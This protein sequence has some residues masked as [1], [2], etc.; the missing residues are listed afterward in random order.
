MLVIACSL[1]VT[2]GS[3]I[4]QPQALDAEEAG[5][6]GDA[7]ATAAASATAATTE[8][9]AV[10][11][12][13]ASLH[14]W[15]AA[16]GGQLSA[17]ILPVN[18]GEPIA[19]ANPD[20]ALNPASNMKLLTAA[21]ALDLLG[22][23]HRFTTGLYGQIQGDVAGP[24]VLR[25][26]GD[27]SLRTAE[28]W[29]LV[30]A[31]TQR[32]VTRID[33]PL[34]VDQTRFEPDFVPPAFDQ[35]PDEWAAFRAPISAIALEQNAVTLNV[36]AARAGE[37]A[38]VW[39]EPPGFVVVEGQVGTR[40]AGAGQGVTLS[41]AER[42]GRLRARVGGHVAAGTGR[43]RF[44]RRV[45]DP[46][47]FAGY[48]FLELARQ[49]GIQVSGEVSPGDGKERRRIA[50]VESE[51][52]GTL[53]N[54]LGKSSDNFYAEMIFRGLGAEAVG[55][56]ARSA[57]GARVVERWL[58]GAGAL[59]ERTRVL[60]GSGL[61]DANRVSSRDL[62]TALTTAYLD[63]ALGADFV[64]QLSIAGVD[65]TLRSRLRQHRKRRIV[66]AK[67]GTLNSVVALSGYALGPEPRDAVA[68][69]FIVEGLPG[70]HSESRRRI[71]ACVD[72][73]VRSLWQ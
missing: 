3:A 16:S 44:R 46:R 57:D 61:F 38:R 68:F 15:V 2:A 69:S 58:H 18:G 71:D 22:P 25:G 47:L 37:P 34:W 17:T 67:T 73:L 42:G 43:L 65:G 30:H 55:E 6:P 11:S 35:Q 31:L 60:N 41:L 28:L 48:V 5:L 72:A 10:A 20:L 66:R 70:K 13:L 19:S 4:G 51:P 29:R 32:G 24:L 53:L 33:G 12:A 54:R 63:P 40:P 36:L 56:P 39:F 8:E 27:P 59:G 14:R 52:L 49:G 62:A 1:P 50:Y 21:A 9:G 7:P 26:H 23:Q 45:E 64:A